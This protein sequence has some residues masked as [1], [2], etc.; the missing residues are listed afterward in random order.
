M[1]VYHENTKVT[2]NAVYKRCVLAF[3]VLRAFVM[4]RR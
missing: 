2:K 1:T 4:S 3:V